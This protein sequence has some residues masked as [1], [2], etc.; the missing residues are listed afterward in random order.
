MTPA[1][2]T[3]LRTY[4]DGDKV[5]KEYVDKHQRL[6]SL[7]LWANQGRLRMAGTA[8]RLSLSPFRSVSPSLSCCGLGSNLPPCS[9]FYYFRFL[10]FCFFS[11]SLSLFL[12]SLVPF[13]LLPADPLSLSLSCSS[14]SAPHLGVPQGRPTARRRPACSGLRCLDKAI[15]KGRREMQG[16]GHFRLPPFSP[17][18]PHPCHRTLTWTGVIQN[19]VFLIVGIDLGR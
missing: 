11:L 9:F 4:T 13:G 17:S 7:A 16:P 19:F 18:V 12:K 1:T 10:V 6:F 8:F 15:Q 2:C 3:C 5:V 14:Y